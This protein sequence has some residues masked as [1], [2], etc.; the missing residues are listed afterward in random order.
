MRTPIIKLLLLA[1]L[2]TSLIQCSNDSESDKVKITVV[3][4]KPVVID[5]PFSYYEPPLT[6]DGE[7]ILVEV[8]APWFI[9]RYSVFNGS[10]MQVTLQT[11]KFTATSTGDDGVVNTFEAN[12][13]PNELDSY[14]INTVAVGA[15]TNATTTGWVI[16]GLP[17]SRNLVYRIKGEMIGWFGPPE[18]PVKSFRQTFDF[19]TSK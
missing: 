17:E 15:S 13:D 10:S 19:T 11:I 3:P 12:L 16:D 9:F 18:S 14:Y 7:P 2:A 5:A 1:G 6:T 8:A 4:E